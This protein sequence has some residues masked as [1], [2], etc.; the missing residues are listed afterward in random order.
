MPG[1]PRAARR[2]MTGVAHEPG[3]WRWISLTAALLLL[4][5]SITFSNV[6][7][8]PAVRWGGEL[9]IELAVCLFVMA[10]A[11]RRFGPPARGIVRGLAAWWVLLVIGRYAEVTAPA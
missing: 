5:A 7:P 11:S 4:D 6:W 10:V 9:S 2:T 1:S 8:T 3:R